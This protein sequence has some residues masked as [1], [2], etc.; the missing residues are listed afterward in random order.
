[1]LDLRSA[2]DEYSIWRSKGLFRIVMGLFAMAAVVAWGVIGYVLLG[3]EEFDALF[4]VVITVATVGYGEVEPLDTPMERI[5]TMGI[6][7][8]GT[9]AVAYLVAGFL[10]LMTEGEVQRLLGTQ[11]LKRQLVTMHHHVIVVG[12][13]RMG[14]LLCEDLVEAKVPFV[15]VERVPELVAEIRR[16]EFLCVVGDATEEA[17]LLE[18]GLGHARA[19]VT[20][21]S[22]DSDAV[23]ITLTA[24]QLA[25]GL[26]IIARAELPTTQRKLMQAGANHVVLTAAIGAKRITSLLANPNAVEFFELVTKQSHLDLEIDEVPIRAGGPLDGR[27]MR[28]ADIG[29]RTGVVVIAVKRAGGTVDFPPNGDT[30]LIG[31]DS[32]VLVGRRT[33]LDSFRAAFSPGANDVK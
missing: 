21:V 14:S 11:Q 4:M 1:M 26:I 15:V 7:A 24:R 29:R 18:A 2:M 5:H 9:I 12:F 10:Q 28:D 23:F 20:A 17:T 30:P 31:G 8:F 25:A 16:R 27:T 33:N 6:I 32:I 19:L 3:W 22:S 13:G